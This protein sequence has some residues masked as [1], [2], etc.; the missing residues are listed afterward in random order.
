MA[1]LQYRVYI[2]NVDELIA[3]SFSTIRTYRG[4]T[5]TGTLSATGEGAALVA[6]QEHYTITI[7][8]GTGNWVQH[9]LYT[10][11]IGSSKSPPVFVAGALT[12][13]DLRVE[14]AR[15]AGAGFA[16]AGTGAGTTTALADAAL[17]D[18]AADANF[19]EG[20]WIYRPNA[21]AAGDRVR[22]IKA[23]GEGW[24]S[25]NLV[26]T[27]AWANAPGTEVYHLFNL[28]PPIDQPGEA[29]SWDRCVRRALGS[30]RFRDE[31]I[32]GEGTSGADQLFDIGAF[33]GISTKYDIKRV[34]LRRY[35]AD[36][37]ISWEQDMNKHGFFWKVYENHEAGNSLKLWLSEP[38]GT[39]DTI[40]LDCVRGYDAIYNDS[41]VTGAPLDLAAATAAYWMAA[42]L[43]L[44]QSGRY[45]I[46]RALLAR[47]A[48]EIADNTRPRHVLKGVKA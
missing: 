24:V 36:G 18:Q 33:A 1:D 44:E 22:R 7:T 47:N 37:S 41:E 10:G 12:L 43:S 23:N 11:S 28:L 2:E 48:H 16:S 38:P 15:V 4:L 34:Y 13:L 14:A 46:D 31:L 42:Q 39:D 8:A 32:L 19:L 35:Q 17:Q 45:G 20:G 9:D 40:V 25:N 6:G 5:A 21:A 3:E 26:P 29:W 27:R 30:V